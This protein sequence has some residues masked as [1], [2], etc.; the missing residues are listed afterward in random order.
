MRPFP[1]DLATLFR[2]GRYAGSGPLEVYNACKGNAR[3]TAEWFYEVTGPG[4]GLPVLITLKDMVQSGDAV[5]RVEGVFSGTISCAARRAL[6][7]RA[8]GGREKV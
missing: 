4:A 1:T 8:E 2:L 5:K 7:L 6:L 3:G